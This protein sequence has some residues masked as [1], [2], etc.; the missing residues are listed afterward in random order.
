MKKQPAYSEFRYLAYDIR[1][2]IQ[3]DIRLDIRTKIARYKKSVLE[4]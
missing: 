3:L 2:D 1:L 4:G